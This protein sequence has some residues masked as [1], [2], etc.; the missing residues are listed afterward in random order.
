[1]LVSK[2]LLVLITAFCSFSSTIPQGQLLV[3]VEGLRN[4]KGSM[5]V[6][7]FDRAEGFPDKAAIGKS[8]EVSG[9]RMT[10]IFKDLK[11]GRYALAIIH[12]ENGN[13]KLDTNAIGIPVEGFCFGNNAMGLVGPPSFKRASVV[14]EKDAITQKLKMRYF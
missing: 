6:G 5:L 9:N 10:V 12:D 8:S 7:L 2:K 11:P 3:V 13:G 1:M 14:I 4:S